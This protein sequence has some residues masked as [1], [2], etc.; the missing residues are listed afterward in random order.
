MKIKFKKTK[1]KVRLGDLP[2]GSLFMYN[3]TIALKSEYHRSNGTSECYIVGSGEAFTAGVST[4][5]NAFNDLLVTP[6]N[7]YKTIQI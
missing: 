2:N 3:E 1:I 4:N 5:R 6:I 7:I